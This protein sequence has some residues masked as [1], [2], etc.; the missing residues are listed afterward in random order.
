MTWYVIHRDGELVGYGTSIGPIDPLWTVYTHEGDRLDQDFIWNP[1]TAAFDIPRSPPARVI[2]TR[3]FMLRIPL[4]KRVAIRGS[5]DPVVVDMVE[6]LYSGPD[7][8][9][10]SP[11]TVQ[12]LDYLQAAGILTAEQVAAA[13]A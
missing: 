2:K 9:L 11:V 10:N 3:D 6:V 12:A 8:D 4:E 13:L 7:V 1:S 5:Q